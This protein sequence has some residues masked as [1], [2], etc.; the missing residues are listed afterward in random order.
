MLIAE[1]QV[2]GRYDVI[3]QVRGDAA[4]VVPVFAEAEEPVRVES[5]RRRRADPL[6]PVDVVIALAL[7]A[8]LRIDVPVPVAVRIVAAVSALRG[9]HLSEHA[10]LY[11]LPPLVPPS[12]RSAL[13]ADLHDALGVA[14]APIDLRG[15]GKGVRHWLVQIYGLAGGDGRQR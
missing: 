14:R 10:A 2:E 5:A 7:R 3:V 1:R 12:P 4:R 15:Y 13:H 9:H 11:H 6:L 8:G